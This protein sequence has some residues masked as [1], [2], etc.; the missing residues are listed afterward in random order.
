MVHMLATG[1]GIPPFLS[2]LPLL[3]KE[4]EVGDATNFNQSS[5]VSLS[6]RINFHVPRTFLKLGGHL[7]PFFSDS[8]TLIF[9]N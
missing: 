6:A 5:I 9:A 7:D 4:R 1:M 2:P 3:D 8:V